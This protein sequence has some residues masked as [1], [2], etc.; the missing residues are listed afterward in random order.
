MGEFPVRAAPAD[1]AFGGAGGRTGSA[2]GA[3]AS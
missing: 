3:T 1:G 2:W